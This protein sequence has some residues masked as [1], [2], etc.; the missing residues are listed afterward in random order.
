MKQ[1]FRWD[2]KRPLSSIASRVLA[3]VFA[4]GLNA[5][6]SSGQN[7]ATLASGLSET[8][9]QIII[10]STVNG[11]MCGSL[12]TSYNIIGPNGSTSNISNDVYLF[13]KNKPKLDIKSLPAGEY[14]LVAITCPEVYKISGIGPIATFIVT[15]GQVTNLGVLEMK[16]VNKSYRGLL[17]TV[18]PFTTRELEG[19][20]EDQPNI[21]ANL[22][23]QPMLVGPS[24]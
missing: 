14:Q 19:L 4:L 5:C 24:L 18:R 20:R 21:A 2:V 16:P 10:H 12:F 1:L 13:Q 11:N 8:N 3:L 9:G 7:N 6:Q 15:A 22:V 23:Y 17:K